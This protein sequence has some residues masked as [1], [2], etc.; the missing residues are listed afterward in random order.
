MEEKTKKNIFKFAIL[1]TLFLVPRVLSMG[2]DI[3]N[4]DALRWHIRS[5]NFSNAMKKG[6]FA[7][8]YQRYHPGVTLMWIGTIADTVLKI[9]QDPGQRAILTMGNADYYPVFH[10]FSKLILVLVISTLFV[11][12]LYAI[13][14]LFG[15]RVA[16]IYGIILSIEPYFIGINRW[17]HLTSLE[18]MFS[19]NSLLFLLLY[20]KQSKKMFLVLSAL[21]CGLGVL[22][23]M[24]V[25]ITAFFNASVLV[26]RIIKKREKLSVL[27]LYVLAALSTFY[28]LFP[29]LWTAPLMVFQKMSQALFNAV[30][31]DPR[32]EL[33]SLWQKVFYYPII[34]LIKTSPLVFIIGLFSIFHNLKSSNFEAKII[35]I[36]FLTVLVFL[37]LSDQKIDR[38]CLALIPSLILSLSV[39]V[40][41]RSKR[42]L[43]SVVSL[44]LLTFLFSTFIYFPVY[45][46]YINPIIPFNTVLSLGFYENSGEYYSNTAMYLNEKG[47]EVKTLIPNNI[48]SFKPYYKG[49]IVDRKND[50]DYV[51][52]GL[53][54]DRPNFAYYEGC[55]P[56]KYFG[57]LIY[58]P[59]AVYKCKSRN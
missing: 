38:Y 28:A 35:S 1:V 44:Q 4:S 36:Y 5:L 55:E 33:M 19:I 57:N 3:S 17:F 23:K 22:T 27:L 7:D 25:I 31:D 54:F 18:V 29:A 11:F 14:R 2:P 12:Q 40:N 32:G 20:F 49:I 37:S 43:F 21:F 16:L 50:A 47:R 26:V 48:D 41:E 13:N 59:L 6:N 42:I 24:T 56:E 52:Y 30:S 53:D 34:L 45:S 58:K 10:G 15:Y 46:A 9:S 8:T 51:V 39:L